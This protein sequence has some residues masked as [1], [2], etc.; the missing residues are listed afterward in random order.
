MKQKIL[1]ILIIFVTFNL[2]AQQTVMFSQYFTNDIIYNPAISGSK[3]YN[4]FVLQTRQQWLGFEGAPLSANVSYNG[5]LNNRS[6]LGCYLEHDR[7]YPSNQTNL[8]LS[9]AYHIPLNADGYYISLGLGAKA[10]YYYVDLAPG[11][12]PPGNDPAYNERSFDK[13]IGD[14]NTGFYLYNSRSYLGYSIL[15]MLKSSFNKES[16]YGIGTNSEELVY[17]GLAGYKFKV[18]RDWDVEPSLQIINRE[19]TE[20]EYNLTTRVFYMDIIWSGLSVRSNSSLSFSVGTNNNDI[21]F[22][23]SFDHYFGEISKYQLGTHEFTMSIR[24]PN[25]NKY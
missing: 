2:R 21:Q 15:N 16:G 9:Y 8:N 6:G 22:A 1:Y 7:T 4:N 5:A 24:I 19:N 10:M 11:D 23:Y 3:E 12:L 13:L 17:V 25:T 18:N 20:N 14:A